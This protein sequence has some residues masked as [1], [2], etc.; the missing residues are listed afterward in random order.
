MA[1]ITLT[2]DIG[3]QDYLV[4]AIKGQLLSQN[5]GFNIVDITHYMSQ[6]NYPQAAYICSNAFKYYPPLTFHIVILNFFD[7]TVNHLLIARHKGQYIICPDNGILTMITG[8]KPNEI[9]RLPLHGQHTL[10]ART[11]IIAKAIEEIVQNASFAVDT[12]TSIDILEKYPLKATIGPDW[13]EGQILFIDNF[14]NVVINITKEEFEEQCN[15]RA[16]SILFT[17]DE[18]ITAIS[19]DYAAIQEGEKLAW[20]NSAGYLEIAINKGNIAGLFG[21]QRYN[22]KMN[23]VGMA[24]QNKWFYQTVKIFFQG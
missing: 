18:Q 20:F 12:E 24:S 9:A 21:L 16:F 22:E 3:Q 10:L 5:S 2:S 4:G 13:M 6:T 14:E 11:Y 15:G 17:R 7:T 1:I 23:K 8:E 19:N